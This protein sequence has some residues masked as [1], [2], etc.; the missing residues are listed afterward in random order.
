MSPLRAKIL[1]LAVLPLLAALAMI[2]AL[3]VYELDQLEHEQGLAQEQAFLAAKR[4]GLRSVV[5]LALTS[6]AHLYG[7]GRDDAEAKREAQAIL[8]AMSFGPDGYFFVYDLDGRNLVHPRLP[9]LEGRPLMDLR[10]E[11][12]VYVIREL[13]A[14]A[15]EGGGFQRY[16]WPKPSTGQSAPKLGY[17]VMLERWGWMLG[18]GLYLD[19]VEAATAGWRRS[20]VAAGRET[21]VVLAVVAALAILSVFA[22][23]LALNIS[24]QRRADRRIRQLADRVVLSQEEERA[25]VSRELHDHVCQLLVSVKYRFEL[26]TRQVDTGAPDAGPQLREAVGHLAEAIGTV[27]RISHELRPPLLD[28]LGLEAALTLLADDFGRRTGLSMRLDLQSSGAPRP[29]SAVAL[30]RIAQEALANVERHAHAR[31][32]QIGLRIDE[33]GLQ[34]DIT[35]DGQGFDPARGEAGDGG[36]GIGLSNMR[37]RAESQGGTLT[38]QSSVAG[39][40]VQVRLPHH[41]TS[42]RAGALEATA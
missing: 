7:A 30:Y 11:N 23:G 9:E 37:Q 5:Q 32:V 33:R 28:D 18:T 24:E 29:A 6:I 17:A 26:A 42:E 1:F 10:D 35:D 20:L 13:I 25:R 22:G 27:R 40:R 39:T 3:L 14:R 2:G 4:D 21:L 41:V 38:I 16:D 15:R 8:R 19:D 36:S 34:L 12:G 31:V